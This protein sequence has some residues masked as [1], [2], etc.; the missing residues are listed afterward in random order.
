MTE[1]SLSQIF[2]QE[3]LEYNPN[4][5][6]FFWKKKLQGR[7]KSRIAGC[8]NPQGYIVIGIDGKTYFAHRLAWLYFYA[9][10][11]N[12]KHIDHINRDRSDNRIEN[13]RLVLPSEN[14]FNKS[15]SRTKLEKRN[16]HRHQV[17][18][19]QKISIFVDLHKKETEE[20]KKLKKSAK[21]PQKQKIQSRLSKALAYL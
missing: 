10:L 3:L 16:G 8:A 2:L 12:S 6:V 9:Y 17:L 13:L 15:P 14:N 1:I 19:K 18:A 20:L 4:T 11:P 5:G 7:R 21:K